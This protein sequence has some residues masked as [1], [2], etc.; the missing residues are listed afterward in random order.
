MYALNSADG[1][2]EWKTK[3]GG[4]VYS[5]P[6]IGADVVFYISSF[7]KYVYALNSADGSVK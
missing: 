1:S 2:V 6:A 7:D 3:T 5:S 4:D